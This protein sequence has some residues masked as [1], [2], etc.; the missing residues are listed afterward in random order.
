MLL[1]HLLFIAL[2]LALV[3]CQ[4][5]PYGTQREATA[6]EK[7]VFIQNAR[8]ELYDPFSIRNAELSTVITL[9]KGVNERRVVCARY[10]SKT[11]DGSYTGTETH[12]VTVNAKN[13][14][15]GSLVVP[16]DEEPC[17]RLRYGPFPEAERL[18]G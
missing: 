7:H 11:K 16:A 12:L 14:V 8:N 10:D 6:S 9:D 2:P 15:T 1:R 4:S 5:G 3:G 13:I 18:K 17:S